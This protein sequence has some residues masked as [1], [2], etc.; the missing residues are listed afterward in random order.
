MPRCH[1]FTCGVFRPGQPFDR[2]RDCPDCWAAAHNPTVA[3]ALGRGPVVPVV[4]GDKPKPFPCVHRG[5]PTGER[6]ACTEGCRP[7]VLIPL[8]SCSQF[9]RCTVGIKTAADVPVCRDCRRRAVPAPPVADPEPFPPG[10]LRWVST[11]DLA[12]DAI[13]LAGL[14]PADVVAVAGV[15]RSGMIP[16]SIIAAHLHLPLYELTEDGVLRKLGHGSRGTVLGFRD[17]P[18]GR[19]AVVDDTVYSGRVMRQARVHM[20]RLNK[21]A[22]CAAV[23]SRLR[24]RPDAVGVVDLYAVALPSPHLLEWNVCNGGPL[25]GMADNPVYGAGVALDIDGVVL[26]DEHSGPVGR[27]HLVPRSAP[28]PLL[29]TGR[30]E[31]HRA[32]TER[33][34]RAAGCKW[35]RLEMLPDAA[36][37]GVESIARHKAGHY[38]ASGC[39]FFVESD[40]A[41]ARLIARFAN[42]PVV[43]PR[44][45]VV[46]GGGA[47]LPPTAVRHVFEP[48]VG[49]RVGLVHSPVGNAGDRLIEA[50]AEQ[51]LRHFGVAYQVVEPDSPGAAEVLALFGGGNYGHPLCGAE[52][53]RR[54]AALATGLPCVLLPQ[55]AYGAEEGQYLAAFV[56]DTASLKHIPGVRLA[57]DLALC[58]EPTRPLPDPAEDLGEFF[59]TDAESLWPGRGTDPAKEITDPQTYLEHVARF[60]RV[61][62]DRVHAAVCGLIAGRDVTLLPTALPKQRAMWEFSLK[63]LGCRWA[64]A[65]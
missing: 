60:R 1:T 47:L 11:A 9:G 50:A 18:G 42:R 8:Q 62:T 34:L 29:V 37:D 19:I 53:R 28:A 31:R 38:A 56:R 51:L 22:V 17:R 54:Q 55:T 33:Q 39:G 23:Y 6:L 40:P 13:T 2:D 64:D 35:V 27:P 58:Y 52:A 21:P 30:R 48:L 24:I 45:G 25:T 5:G 36:P 7:G 49:K 3:A 41:Q 63:A 46:C 16:A 20:T 65:P 4:K 10:D 43:C 26:H 15:P 59:S 44:V 57:P 14:L 12:R 61:V 32:A